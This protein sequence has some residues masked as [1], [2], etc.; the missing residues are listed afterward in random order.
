MSYFNR[1][2]RIFVPP[3]LQ[4]G[5]MMPDDDGG[6]PRHHAMAYAPA[7]LATMATAA[8]VKSAVEAL[9]DANKQNI[10]DAVENVKDNYIKPVVEKIKNV[11]MPELHARKGLI[12][13]KY[14]YLGPFTKFDEKTTKDKRGRTTWKEGEE[15]T[16]INNL[17]KAAFEHDKMYDRYQKIKK[18]HPNSKQWSDHLL[19]K[20]HKADDKLVEQ[21]KEHFSEDRPVA[22]LG[23]TAIRLKQFLE[24]LR[25][26]PRSWISGVGLPMINKINEL[27]ITDPAHKLKLKGIIEQHGGAIPPV[28]IPILASVA[29]T[30]AGKIFDTIKEKISGKGLEKIKTDKQKQRYLIKLCSS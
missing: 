2:R 3:S 26:F 20:I 18:N 29:A 27:D 14:N 7:G 13:K 30:V 28:L 11:K 16:P 24:K 19:K 12:G 1:S 17:D 21:F 10:N 23:I 4:S 5:G 15:S 22:A 9:Y 6:I 8:I 25:L